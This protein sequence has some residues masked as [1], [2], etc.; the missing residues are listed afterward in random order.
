MTISVRPAGCRYLAW[1]NPN[2]SNFT[3]L[4]KEYGWIWVKKRK[5]KKKAEAGLGRV[6]VLVKTWPKLRPGL[7]RLANVK[8]PKETYLYIYITTL[9]LKLI[10]LSTKLL[11]S[12]HLTSLTKRD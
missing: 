8:L 11:L 9:T 4:D 2:G 1:P 5:K 10:S 3:R 6:R 12:P 7:T